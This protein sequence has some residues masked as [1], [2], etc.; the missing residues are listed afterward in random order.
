M[1]DSSD[2]EALVSPKI[3]NLAGSTHHP[4]VGDAAVGGNLCVSHI[5]EDQMRPRKVG[6]D[7]SK[8]SRVI[9]MFWTKLKRETH[10]NSTQETP[11]EILSSA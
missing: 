4:N 3:D 6:R 2:S 1:E 10:L 5:C 7:L 11:L 9:E 8:K